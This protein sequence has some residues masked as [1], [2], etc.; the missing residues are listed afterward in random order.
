MCEVIQHLGHPVVVDVPSDRAGNRATHAQFHQ[1][2]QHGQVEGGLQI[3]GV[4][5]VF[6]RFPEE[7]AVRDVVQFLGELE[8][9]GVAGCI[10]RN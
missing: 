5:N 1:V 7:E 2:T 10:A 9:V 3:H 6:D 4:L 8:E